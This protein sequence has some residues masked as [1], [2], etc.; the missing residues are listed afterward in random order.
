MVV[1]LLGVLLA[2]DLRRCEAPESLP[3]LDSYGSLVERAKFT[4]DVQWNE[5]AGDF[6]PVASLGMPSH[7]S[8]RLRWTNLKAWPELKRR[9]AE[10]LRFRAT[11]LTVD[12]QKVPHQSRW[13]A[14]Y[15]ATIDEVC[16]P[17]P[18]AVAPPR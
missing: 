8:S 5:G 6:V 15:D 1:W 4:V 7:H 18:S 14:T 17:K 12:L 13:W 10:V 16:L 2:G 11:Y 9:H 3:R